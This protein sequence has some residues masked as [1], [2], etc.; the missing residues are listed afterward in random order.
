MCSYACVAAHSIPLDAELYSSSLMEGDFVLQGVPLTDGEISL[1]DVLRILGEVEL[2]KHFTKE[3]QLIFAWCGAGIHGPEL[4][5]VLRR[6]MRWVEVEEINDSRFTPGELVYK[7]TFQRE[8]E[9]LYEAGLKPADAN[10]ALVGITKAVQ[11][12][13]NSGGQ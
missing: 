1:H 2:K 5:M 12:L 8:N 11:L 7:F 6:M 13:R 4:E 3:M 9:R 10:P